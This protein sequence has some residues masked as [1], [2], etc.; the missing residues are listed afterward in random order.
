MTARTKAS[1][2]QVGS[3]PL[4]VSVEPAQ[5]TQP[6]SMDSKSKPL[7]ASGLAN[8]TPRLTPLWIPY[9]APNIFVTYQ[10][11]HRSTLGGTQQLASNCFFDATPS[12][13][14]TTFGA[15]SLMRTY[16]FLLKLRAASARSNIVATTNRPPISTIGCGA[17]GAAPMWEIL[18]NLV[19]SPSPE[20]V[21]NSCNSP[22]C[23]SKCCKSQPVNLGQSLQNTQY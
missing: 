4:M 14:G 22:I 18:I 3:R 15:S 17:L 1:A 19:P 2:L 9:V 20:A 5:N 10:Q 21:S 16:S 11:Q 6:D 7:I 12:Q 8:F 23:C 13:P